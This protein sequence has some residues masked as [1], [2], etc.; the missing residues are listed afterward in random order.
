MKIELS[1]TTFLI[2]AL[3]GISTVFTQKGPKAIAFT[4]NV[5]VE[6][7]QYVGDENPEKPDPTKGPGWKLGIALYTFNPS[8]LEEQ[9]ELVRTT[10]LTYIE[11]YTFGKA[12]PELK[13]SL[14]MNLSS[15]GLDKLYQTIEKSGLKM[16]SIYVIGGKTIDKWVK[17]FE[18]AKHLKVR[19]VTAEPPTNL[20]N[21]VDSL[22]GVYGI[23]V[24]LHNHWKGT[25]QYWHPD[26]VLAALKNH[27]NMG[28]CPDV[29][30]WP[31][32]GINPT[33]GIKK[34]SG[35]IIAMHLKDIAEY[36]NPKLKD[37]TVGTGVIKFPEIFAELKRQKFSG[38]MMIERDQQDKPNNLSSVTQ[39][40][41]YYKEIVK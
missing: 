29:G 38:N 37:V 16:E 30:H 31:K 32:S 7:K 27:P 28:A 9:F 39:S 18:I 8:P 33:E 20:L 41:R 12:G 4:S 40:I 25:S 13:D 34:L 2:S 17:D 22:A 11:G 19:Y 21:S 10:G 23:K 24:A 35:H 15:S 6:K 14:I 3:L 1:K 5:Q 36:D 26:S